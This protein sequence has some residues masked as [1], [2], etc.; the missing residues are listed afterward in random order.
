MYTVIPTET[1]LLIAPLISFNL[2]VNEFL[3]AFRFRGNEMKKNEKHNVGT[4]IISY[5]YD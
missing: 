2:Y 1:L 4:I 3:F 5:Q